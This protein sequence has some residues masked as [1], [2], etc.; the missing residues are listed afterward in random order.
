[1]I[2][3]TMEDEAQKESDQST[4]VDRTGPIRPHQTY[5]SHGETTSQDLRGVGSN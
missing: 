3:F 1:M 5:A 2:T 4:H